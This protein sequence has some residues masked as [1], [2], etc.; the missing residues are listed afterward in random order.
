MPVAPCRWIS[1]VGTSRWSVIRDRGWSLEQFDRLVL[2]NDSVYGPLFPLDEMWSSFEGADMYGAIECLERGQHLQSFFLAW[3]L[4]SR[5]RP[6]LNDFWNGFQYV[7]DKD[8]LIRRHEIGLSKRARNAGLSIKPFVSAA[9]IESACRRVPA[10]QWADKLALSQPS[11]TRLLLLGRPDRAL[12]I[13]VPEDGSARVLTIRGTTPWL[14]S[15]IS[16]SSAP[17]IRTHS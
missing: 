17:T 16:S 15:A 11:T 6:F 7:V 4:N 2:A 1:A 8:I 9:S 13:P 12:A 14:T 5:T 3:D 10:H